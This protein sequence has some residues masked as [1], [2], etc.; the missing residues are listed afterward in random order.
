MVSGVNDVIVRSDGEII[1]A[2]GAAKSNLAASV[3]I[4]GGGS[5]KVAGQVSLHRSDGVSVSRESDGQVIADVVGNSAD[6]ATGIR[7]RPDLS[8]NS[9]F[10]LRGEDQTAF[11]REP[12]E[13]MERAPVPAGHGL[14]SAGGDV[15]HYQRARQTVRLVGIGDGRD[16]DLLAGGP[17]QNVE[18]AVLEGGWVRGQFAGAGAVDFGDHQSDFIGGEVQRGIS[19]AG[20]IRGERNG[21]SGRV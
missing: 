2:L 17:T 11:V 21:A 9:G 6:N 18:V 13:V 14:L 1:G 7:D 20:A 8:G 3:G 19:H 15:D 12:N 10:V 5:P 16:D 4:N